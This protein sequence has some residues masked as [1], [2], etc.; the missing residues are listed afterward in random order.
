MGLDGDEMLLFDGH[1]LHTVNL[2]TGAELD[3][4]RM[5]ESGTEVWIAGLAGPDSVW[6]FPLVPYYESD[7]SSTVSQ[8]DFTGESVPSFE[9]EPPFR[10][11]SANGTDLYLDGPGESWVFDTITSSV[12]ALN[13][14]IINTNSEAVVLLSCDSTLECQVRIDTGTR[15][16]PI[17]ALT[18]A[19]LTSGEVQI[20]PDLTAAFVHRGGQDGFEITAFEFT[21]IDLET[22][23]RFELGELPIEPDPGI[24]WVPNT[25]WLIAVGDR[26]SRELVAVNTSTGSILELDLPGIGGAVL[27]LGLLPS[28]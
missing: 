17:P 20:A 5:V 6:L 23:D 11:R 8:V 7:G 28:S 2:T 27:S 26:A 15:L 4:V 1:A 14:E 10:V 25:S 19:D 3:Q 22:G 21:Y 12:T 24:I 16:A 13:G 18:A 9:F